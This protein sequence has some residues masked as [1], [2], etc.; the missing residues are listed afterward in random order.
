MPLPESSLSTICA[1][2]TDFVRTGIGAAV[3]SI[4]V[5]IGAP[6]IIAGDDSQHRL[7]LFFYRFEPSGFDSDVHPN[8]PWR[9][10]L[11][12]LITAFGIDEDIINAGENDLRLIGEVMRIFQPR[13]TSTVG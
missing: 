2:I 7:N 4:N 3:N 11:F 5:S 10:R 8:D 1:S 6:A 12:C 9:I 13:R